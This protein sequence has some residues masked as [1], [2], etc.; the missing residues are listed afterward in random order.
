MGV[1]QL[2][3]R[4]DIGDGWLLLRSLRTL[5]VR[6]E[7]QNEN[8]LAL[9]QF[10]ETHPRVECVNYPGLES[11]PQH[12]LARRQMAGFTGVLSVELR[13]NYESRSVLFRL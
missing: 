4:Y 9:A 12:Q 5:G 7:R 1:V 2:L 11:H 6:V 8:A 13:G 10:L 3:Y